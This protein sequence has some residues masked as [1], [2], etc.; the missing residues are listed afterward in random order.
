MKR[1]HPELLVP[2]RGS[3]AQPA[4]PLPTLRRRPHERPT[5]GSGPTNGSLLPRRRATLISFSMPVVR[6]LPRRA[7]TTGSARADR[8]GRDAEAADGAQAQDQ[9]RP[10]RLRPPQ[11][12]RR[13]RVRADDHHPGRQTAPAPRP[14]RRPCPMAVQLRNPQPLEAPP[15]RRPRPDPTTQ[16]RP[17]PPAAPPR[18]RRI[19][20]ELIP[21]RRRRVPTLVPTSPLPAN[22]DQRVRAPYGPM[23]PS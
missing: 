2:F 13:A 5:H 8:E 9:T 16:H 18:H 7:Q 4:R 11:D 1:R 21:Q 20:P 22:T 19:D 12:D 10:Q 15:Q 3:I 17:R 23:L 14:R 6:R